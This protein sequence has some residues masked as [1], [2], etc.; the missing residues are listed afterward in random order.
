MYYTFATSVPEIPMAN[1]ISAFFR[2]GAS[3][4]PSPVTATIFYNSYN[5]VTKSN[6]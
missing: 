1:P 6:L 2:A 4:V 3:F 5:P